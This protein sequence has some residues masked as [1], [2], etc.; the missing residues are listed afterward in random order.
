MR[1]A[2]L[3]DV[4]GCLPKVVSRRPTPPLAPEQLQEASREEAGSLRGELDALRADRQRL[5]A[6][7]AAARDAA[8]EEERKARA[9]ADAVAEKDAMIT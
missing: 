9:A 3:H 4:R 2:Q 5:D 8:R 6:A 1:G 7:L